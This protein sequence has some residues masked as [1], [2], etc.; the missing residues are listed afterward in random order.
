MTWEKGRQLK[1]FD[2]N[3]Y[4]YNANGNRTSKTINGVTHTYT[5]DGTKILREAWEDN[6]LIPLYDN[7]ESVCGIIYNG[8]PYYFIKN[9]Q[10][11]VI[12][13]VNKD[14]ET[15]AKYSYDA[16]GVPTILQDNSDCQIATINPFRYRDYYYDEETGLY[17]V[18]SRYYDP[19]IGRWLNSDEPLCLLI[20]R[21]TQQ[22]NICCY[23]ENSPIKN[24]DLLG[25]W[26][27]DLKVSSV[28]SVLDIIL[29]ILAL[30]VAFFAPLKAL[31]WSRKIFSWAK[32]AFDKLINKIAYVLA[33]SLD[34]IMYE[35]LKRYN[36]VGKVR[37][38]I[39]ATVIALYVSKLIDLSPGKIVAN[40]IDCFDG[41][42]K[43]G[44]IRF[45]GDK[46]EQEKRWDSNYNWSCNN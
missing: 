41:D 8:V 35:L 27:V 3:T 16:W 7:E 40:I 36:S 4:T 29:A 17:Y 30:G 44:H 39:G 45:G 11:D 18:S 21:N 20:A 33:N 43:N 34:T 32:R 13:I 26:A 9:L 37:I 22:Y 2:G 15:V 12:A 25:Y 19:E 5:L 38:S 10:G 28:A 14:A 23:C 1:S 42:G 6:I 46:I 31:S 24:V